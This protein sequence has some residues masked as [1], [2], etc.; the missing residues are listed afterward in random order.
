MN[1]LDSTRN[2][3]AWLKEFIS[4]LGQLYIIRIAH[5]QKS[6]SD[7]K[8]I[9]FLLVEFD[10]YSYLTKKK[11]SSKKYFGNWILRA[12][13]WGITSKKKDFYLDQSITVYLSK[14]ASKAKVFPQAKSFVLQVFTSWHFSLSSTPRTLFNWQCRWQW[15]RRS[16]PESNVTW[17]QELQDKFCY[18][19]Q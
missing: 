3:P 18:Q 17:C 10:G 15:C 9:L 8:T 16:W 4:P 13:Q 7:F 6:F 19:H 1:Y 14:H 5:L 2:N 12:N 11:I